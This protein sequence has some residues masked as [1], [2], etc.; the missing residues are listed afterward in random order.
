M[1]MKMKVLPR[2]AERA[3]LLGRVW[4]PGVGP[5]V[6][7]VRQGKAIDISQS[8][9]LSALLL[10]E[11]EPAKALAAAAL[12]GRDLGPIAAIIDNS[13]EPRRDEAKPF[14]LAPVDLQAIKACGVTFAESL[15]ER[16]IE[17]RTKGD[18][19]AADAIR[20]RL[21]AELGVD[22][23]AIKPGSEAARKAKEMLLGRGL[24]SQYLEVGIGPDAEV[25]TKA[26]PMSALG[27]GARL[28]VHP[29]SQWSNPEP[30]VVL[31]VDARGRLVGAT[32]GNDV[33][34]RDFEGRSALL[35]GRSK[36]NNGACAIGPFIR[37]LD[38][39]FGL[40][41][42]RK[43]DL[44]LEIAGADGF[45][46]EAVSSMSKISRDP[47]DLIAQTM[48][49][50]HQYPDGMVLFTGTMFAPTKDRD[51]PGE[52]FTHKPGDRVAIA[53]E[54]L[55]TLANT[56]H[57]ADRIAPWDFGVIALMRNLATRQ[58]LPH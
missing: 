31:V 25:F 55:G 37:L 3:L 22:L 4:L 36:D 56:V 45:R 33:N 16:V 46:L 57:H 58:L 14:L 1:T 23:A 49:N 28:G 9:A 27:H 13:E 44:A 21:M 43:A 53:S 2:D 5:A 29:A 48:G 50:T 11:A 7:A 24:W 40:E 51:R 19:R 30:E 15:L 8:F 6:I 54:K 12:K 35:L 20:N 41:D 17:E 26:Q 42:V 10:N 52:G 18:P 38:G 39:H 34:L 47:L 32:L